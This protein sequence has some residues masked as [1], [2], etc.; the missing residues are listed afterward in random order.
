MVNGDADR[1]QVQLKAVVDGNSTGFI[2]YPKQNTM[3]VVGIIDGVVTHS[4]IVMCAE[5]DKVK[6]IIGNNSF[7][8]DANTVTAQWAKWQFNNGSNDG[9]VNIKPLVTKINN[10]ENLVNN[11]LTVLKSTSVPTPAGPYPFAPLYAALNAIAPIT[12]QSDLE[13]TNVTH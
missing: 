11:I 8:M 12:Q 4:F 2:L 9:L 5:V 1:L 3:V 7:I 10:L 6:I 13:D